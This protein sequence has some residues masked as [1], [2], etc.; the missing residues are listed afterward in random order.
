M[1]PYNRRLDPGSN[2]AYSQ[3]TYRLIRSGTLRNLFWIGVV[4]RIVARAEC[5]R[6][7]SPPLS[8]SLVPPQ[9]YEWAKRGHGR[10]SGAACPAAWSSALDNPPAKFNPT[11]DVTDSYCQDLTRGSSSFSFG[12]TDQGGPFA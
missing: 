4:P 9:S 10:I 5:R 1:S 6:H 8:N 12:P 2:C 3:S 7:A 11:L